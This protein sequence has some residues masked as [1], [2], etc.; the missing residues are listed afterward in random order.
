MGPATTIHML[1][2]AVIG[3]AVLSPIAKYQ[4]WA[5]GEVGDWN[6]GSKG[7]I[8][9]ISLAIMLSDAIV[10]LGWLILRPTIW[11]SRHYGPAIVRGVRE[12]GVRRQ[13]S[14]FV[15][16][17][18][19]GYSPVNLS[20][21]PDGNGRA[22]GVAKNTS[23]PDSAEEEE[24]YDAPPEHQIGVKTTL[25]GLAISL[26]FCIFAVQFSFLSLIHI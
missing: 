4:G 26:I 21:P 18:V 6:T 17:A 11:Y 2:G 20:D 25:L 22:N 1:L 7:W 24:E 10:S 16:P 9:W 8:V 14:D 15:S 3:W 12:K 5:S 13:L 23:A 19:R